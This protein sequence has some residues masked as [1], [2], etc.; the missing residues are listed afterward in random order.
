MSKTDNKNALTK[1][2]DDYSQWYLDVIAAA[3]LAEHSPVKG[4]M[5]IKPYGYAIWE[6]IQKVLD[7]KIKATGHQNA[8]F[9]LF[10]PKSFLSREASHVKG[11]AKE[12]AVVTHHRLINDPASDG[13]M[14]DPAA[15]LEEELV[16]RPT[17]ETIIYAMYSKWIKSWR[18][19]PLLINQWANIVRWEM[20][21]RLFLRTTE[22]LWQEG[23]TVHA[24]EQEAEDEARKILDLYKGF[25]EEY[26]AMPVIQG[27]KSESEKFAG[28]LRTYCIEAMMQDG[29]ALQ[30]GT[31]H[32]LGQ[33][34]AKAFNIQFTDQDGTLKYAWQTSWGVSTRLIGALIMCHSDDKGLVLPPEIAPIKVVIV[35]IGKTQE[36]KKLV[37]DKIGELLIGF[38]SVDPDFDAR[39]V[40][41]RRED[42]TPGYKFNEWEK[43]GVPIRIEIGPK[44]VAANQLVAVY[45]DNGEKEAISLA[46]NWV[47]LLKKRLDDIQQRLFERAKARLNEDSYRFDDY[48]KFKSQL[49]ENPG[50]IYSHWCGSDKCEAE[51]AAETKATICCIPFDTAAE[52]GKCIKCNSSSQK[53]VIFAKAY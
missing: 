6:N 40:Y 12:C 24:T 19:L 2:S 43:K 11:F 30:A 50:F 13:V 47:A 3:D 53:R 20:R 25:T 16:V 18:D 23:H 38:K 34:F 42:L 36:E 31:S 4:C 1:R 7:Q 35:P 10:V 26:L 37:E 8:Y 21:T 14:V 17:S 39:R 44:D 49:A 15:K 52:T 48:D 5:V 46:G 51:I 22:F 28:A 33:N 27:Q 9:P 29:R 41:D 45:R 32:H